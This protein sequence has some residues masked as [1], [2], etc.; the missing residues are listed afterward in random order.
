MSCSTCSGQVKAGMPAP[1]RRPA[2]ARPPAVPPGA[3]RLEITAAT[4]DIS[5]NVPARIAAWSDS[6]S[7]AGSRLLAR[8]QP[9]GSLLTAQRA[10]FSSAGGAQLGDAGGAQL[11]DAGGAQLGGEPLAAALSAFRGCGGA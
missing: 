8:R 4:P 10:S 5:S 6:A 2:Q 7:T 3:H 1:D 9:L 11:G